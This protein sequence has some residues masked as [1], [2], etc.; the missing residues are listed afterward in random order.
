[1]D[2]PGISLMLRVSIM[3]EV[4]LIIGCVFYPEIKEAACTCD[5]AHTG[6]LFESTD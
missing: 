3:R 5:Y 4:Q 6:S 1:M 2:E